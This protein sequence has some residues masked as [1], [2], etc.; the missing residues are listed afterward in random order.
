MAEK[1]Y[2][3]KGAVQES[4]NAMLALITGVGI[5]ILALI[6]VG[7]L[8]GQV[9]SNVEPDIE[10][11]GG[12]V[13]NET[14]GTADANGHFAGYL[15]KT[16]VVAGSETITCGGEVVPD[17]NYTLNYTSG[18]LE[19]NYNTTACQNGDVL[20]TYD[21]GDAAIAKSIKAAIVSGFKALKLSGGYMPILVLA[22]II[23]L[24]LGLV[25]SAARTT[26][27]YATHGTVL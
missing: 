11:I 21:W 25:I 2:E 23:A 16:P 17:A 5:G 6:F 8:G 7:V 26:T 18:Y 19:V 13:V 4:T 27:N 20:A 3:K 1:I 22:A 14:V 24:V 15:N 10:S 12:T 9:Y